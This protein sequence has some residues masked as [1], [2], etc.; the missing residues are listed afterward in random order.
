MEKM[1]DRN[2]FISE[3]LPGTQ[4]G[5]TLRDVY[6]YLAQGRV[7][8]TLD[9]VVSNRTVCLTKYISILRN[10]YGIDI[11]DR[12]IKLGNRKKIKQYWLPK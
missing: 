9:A 1:D 4:P 5:S 3:V 10:R 11:K 7:L 2:L 12:W 6:E 8:T